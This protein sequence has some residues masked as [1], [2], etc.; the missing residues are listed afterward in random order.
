MTV[1]PLP[2]LLGL[3]ASLLLLSTGQQEWL[4]Q[5]SGSESW[6]AETSFAALQLRAQGK[7]K[8]GLGLGFLALTSIG[9]EVFPC[10][11]RRTHAKVTGEDTP[12]G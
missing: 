2:R 9:Y 10:D 6:E 8:V 11:K 12:Q 1:G 4:V 5:S 7:L 3:A